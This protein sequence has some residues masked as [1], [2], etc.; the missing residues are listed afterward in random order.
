MTESIS[1]PHIQKNHP[2]KSS[3]KTHA[4]KTTK[5]SIISLNVFFKDPSS[6][7][8]K[9]HAKL[10]REAQPYYFNPGY[11]PKET[12]FA[13]KR[14][15]D[16]EKFQAGKEAWRKHFKE[17]KC[18]EKSDH[19]LGIFYRG[20]GTPTKDSEKYSQSPSSYDDD[21]D[22]SLHHTF[23]LPDQFDHKDSII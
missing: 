16:Y 4:K 5:Q 3:Q 9:T 2:I 7:T 22:S 19:T 13:K 1:H 20:H 23:P 12:K 18:E 10:I 17:N 15:A 21:D 8:I 14:R 11:K 6:K